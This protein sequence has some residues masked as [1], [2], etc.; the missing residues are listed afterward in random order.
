M[1]FTQQSFATVGAQS[2]DTPN[3]YGYKSTDSL[4]TV[5]V[6]GYFVDKQFQLEEGDFIL[7][8]LSDFNGFLE[9]D[10]TSQG[11]KLVTDN[12]Q[13]TAYGELATAQLEPEIQI[14]AEYNVMDDIDSVTVGTGTTAVTGGEVVATA[15]GAADFAVIFSE[16]QI[17]SRPGQGSIARFTARFDAGLVDSRK[18]A[19]LASAGDAIAFGYIDEVFGTMYDHG[20]LNAINELQ[21]T[22]PATGVENATV[23]INGTPF[24]VPLTDASGDA[25]HTVN[26]IVDSLNV[27]DPLNAYSSNDDT[28]IVRSIFAAPVIGAFTFSSATAVGVFTEIEAGLSPTLEFTAQ[29]EWSEDVMSSLNPLMTNSYTI[30]WNGDIE[31]YIEDPEQGRAILVHRVKLSNNTIIPMFSI[32]SFQIA[33]NSSNTGNTIATSVYGT[34]GAAFNEGIRSLTSPTSSANNT[35]AGVTSTLTNILTLKGRSVFG[36]KINLGRLVPKLLTAATDS[37]QG[38]LLQIINGADLTVIEPDYHYIDKEGS[39]AQISTTASTVSG[40]TVVASFVLAPGG[41]VSVAQAFFS[42]LISLEETQ[43]Y[44]MS[45]LSGAASEMSVSAVWEEDK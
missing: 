3:L 19:G 23:T 44:A 43:T 1:S 38:A 28:V 34:Q 29:T 17:I 41:S 10:E 21:I 14:T 22:T 18:T 40:G 15:T 13:K 6:A 24:T 12:L 36:T 2:T 45:I 42:S 39:I 26:E 32:N 25:H 31:Y 30:Q 9:V 16:R 4:S 35:V 11:V 7:S 5:L 20:G 27:Q 8:Q 33:W 37:N